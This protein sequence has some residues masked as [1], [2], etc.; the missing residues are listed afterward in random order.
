MNVP[1]EGLAEFEVLKVLPFDSNRK[2][3][4]IVV[5]RIGASEVTLYTKGA[6]TSIFQVLAPIPA[7]SFEGALREQTQLQL[8][9]YAKDGL[10]VLVLAK[11]TLTMGEYNEWYAKHKQLEMSHEHRDKRIRESYSSLERNLRLLGATGIEDRLQEGV[12]ETIAALISAGIIVWVLTGDKPETAINIAYAAK[13]FQPQWELLKLTARSRDAAE[14]SIM[15]YLSEIEKQ[16]AEFGE[17]RQQKA[18]V[19]D[20]K[21][22]TYM[23]DM[24]SNLVKPFLRLTKYCASVL[25]C[26]STPLQKAYLVKV[27]KEEYQLRTLAIGDGANDVSMIQMADVGVGISGQEGMQAVMAADFTLPRFKYLENLLL[28]H[29]FW[30]YDR[31]ARMILYFFYKNAVSGGRGMRC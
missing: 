5:R 24:R 8:D 1:G 17:L 7:D 13:L 20:G 12:P 22:L 30:S 10:R 9:N 2:C 23:L 28:I 25:C 26:R 21:T 11:K 29:G 15:F 31:L 4:S 14:A 6:D 18:L 16:I 3:M 19:V 27:V